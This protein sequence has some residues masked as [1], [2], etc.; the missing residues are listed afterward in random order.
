MSGR[1]K[2]VLTFDPDSGRYVLG[3]RE[4]HCGDCFQVRVNGEWVDTR[5]ELS[6]GSDWYLYHLPGLDLDR[7]EARHYE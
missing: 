7:L 3:G 2:Q 5:I 6:G 1:N 4:L